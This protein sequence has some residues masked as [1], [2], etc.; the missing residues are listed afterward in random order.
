M[1]L[2]ISVPLLVAI[3][4][5]LLWLVLPVGPNWKDAGRWS[6]LIGLTIFLLCW[7]RPVLFSVH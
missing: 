7:C 4:G 3:V 6:Y 1:T 2:S 5:L